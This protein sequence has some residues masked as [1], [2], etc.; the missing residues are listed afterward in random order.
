MAQLA[1]QR[2]PRAMVVESTFR[3]VRLMARRFLMPGFLVADPFD[4]EAVLAELDVP[5][6]FFH[7]RHDE[8]IPYAHG[9]ELAKTAPQGRL[10]TYECGHNDLPPPGADYW[11]AITAHLVAAGVLR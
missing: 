8:V 7:G 5:V 6:L 9:V 3:S 11:P 10:V 1:A 4:T 2:A